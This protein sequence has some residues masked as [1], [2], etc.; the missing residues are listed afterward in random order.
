MR[1]LVVDALRLVGPRTAMGRYIEYMAQE[2]SHTEVPF[3]RIVLMS[4]R[5]VQFDGVGS[6][7]P[8]VQRSFGARLPRAFW[9]QAALS[10]A[11]RDAAMLFGPSYIVPLVH[12]G[13]MVV[14][15]HG[16]YERLPDEVPVVQ[17]LRS[18]PLH[19]ASARRAM[20]VIANS[21]QT[22]ADV[23]EFFGVPEEKIDV[24]YP[25]A[26]GIFFDEHERPKIAREVERTIGARLPYVIF[27]G[28]LSKRRH[29]PNLI[30][31]FAT[32]RRELSLPHRLLIVGPNTR[33]LDLDGLSAAHGLN[34]ALVYV[35]HLAQE[36]LALL[37]AGAEA[38]VL[39]TSYEGISYTMFEAMA[40]GTPVL[41]VDHPVLEEGGADSVLTVP[42]A[43]VPDLVD[44]LR[45]ILLDQRL[46]EELRARGRARASAFSWSRAADE[47]MAI[48]D[49][50][51]AP[52][53]R[54]RR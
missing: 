41:T 46:R 6:S 20:R 54:A 36:A 19:R 28:K 39:P 5:P 29:V 33:R 9:E 49:E 45:S 21:K 24:V 31:A 17:R 47:T 34:G 14:A 51:A 32:V 53:D 35:P 40:S 38:F 44:G 22:K 12:W 2:W 16:I 43:S 26:N 25:A 52:A 50:V 42:T 8:V 11:A 1:T 23:S 48:L 37:Y 30:E 18:T 3:D 13:P 27:V 7:T 4:P 10:R 15:N